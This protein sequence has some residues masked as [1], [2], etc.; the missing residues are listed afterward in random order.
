[1]AIRRRTN[2]IPLYAGVPRLRPFASKT[3]ALHRGSTGVFITPQVELSRSDRTK[4]I[5]DAQAVALYATPDG[6]RGLQVGESLIDIA[7]VR[8]RGAAGLQDVRRMERIVRTHQFQHVVFR[9]RQQVQIL[10]RD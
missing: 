10:Q 4:H 7:H 5:T 2:L 3:L 8:F 6:K 1:M 9:S